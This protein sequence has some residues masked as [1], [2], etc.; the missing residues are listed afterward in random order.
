MTFLSLCKLKIRS[1][2]EVK[3]PALILQIDDEAV[4]TKAKGAQET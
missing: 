2:K 3:R 4:D 1:K